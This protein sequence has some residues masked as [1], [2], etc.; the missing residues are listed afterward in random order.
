M[1]ITVQVRMDVARHLQ[2]RGPPTAEAETL[3]RVTKQLGIVLEPIHPGTADPDLA[4]YFT[5]EAPD[6]A[7]AERVIAGL[8]QSKAV[9]AAYVKPPDAMP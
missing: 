5:V 9:E 3:N 8:Q 1:Q 4:R 2:Q 7:T 6:Q